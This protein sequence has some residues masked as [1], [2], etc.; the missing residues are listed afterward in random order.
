[1]APKGFLFNAVACGLKKEGRLD[2]GLIYCPEGAVCAGVFTQNAVKAAPVLLGEEVVKKG[3]AWGILVN[4]GCANACTGEA[5]LKDARTLLTALAEE[6]GK[7]PSELLPASTGVIGARLP[8][9]KMLAKLPA[10]VQDLTPKRFTEVA[11]AMMTTDTFPKVVKRTISLGGES[12]CVLGLAKGAGMIAPNMA[13]MLAFILTD[14]RIAPADLKTLLREAV[15][16]SFNRI[17]VDGDTSTNDTVY[18]LASGAAGLV[19]APGSPGFKTL[20]EAFFEVCRELAYLIVKDGEGAKKTVRIRVSGCRTEKEALILARTVAN[21]LLVK[22]ALFGEDPN[23]G[24]IL[25]AMGRSEVPFDP[26][27][28]D[29]AIGPVKIVENG[30]GLGDDAEKEAHRIMTQKEFEVLITLKEGDKEADVLTCDLSYDYVRI[31]AEYRT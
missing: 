4:S 6:L 28:V 18:A 14:A 3:R 31:N 27:K 22:T 20:E 2:L 10:L 19:C 9:E 8:V 26:Y 12:A 15:S 23:W 13:T 11:R 7:E 1:M 17:T 21:S 5:G 16:L 29:I 25:A 30:L 24:R